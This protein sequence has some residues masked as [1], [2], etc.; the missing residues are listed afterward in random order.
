MILVGCKCACGEFSFSVRYRAPD[1]DIADYMAR[2]V[3]PA[4]S[5]AHITRAPWCNV[6]APEF[7]RLPLPIDGRGIGMGPLH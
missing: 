7:I 2:A 6:P 3:S 1:E 5:E 4:L